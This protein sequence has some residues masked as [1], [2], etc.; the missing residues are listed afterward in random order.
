MPNVSRPTRAMNAY[1][2]ACAR[3]AH[4]LIRALAARCGE[5]FAAEKGLAA[6]ECGARG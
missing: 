6:R 5:E 4:R 3:G 2:A 1:F